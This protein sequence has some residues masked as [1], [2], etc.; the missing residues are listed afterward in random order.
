MH[1]LHPSYLVLYNTYILFGAM[2]AFDVVVCYRGNS[3]TQLSQSLQYNQC[4]TTYN[5][6]QSNPNHV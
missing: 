5:S 6:R 4:N 2:F 1:V 3:C